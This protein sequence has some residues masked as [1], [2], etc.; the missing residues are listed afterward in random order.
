MKKREFGK[1]AADT[2]ILCVVS[3]HYTLLHLALARAVLSKQGSLLFVDYIPMTTTFTKVSSPFTIGVLL[4]P[5]LIGVKATR[6]NYHVAGGDT[7][8]EA[9]AERRSWTS[10]LQPAMAISMFSASCTP[11]F[12]MRGKVFRVGVCYHLTFAVEL[13]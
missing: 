5:S 9:E 12:S 8:I 4:F 10:P 6:L 11:H 2:Y 13:G 1:Q 7:S 3:V